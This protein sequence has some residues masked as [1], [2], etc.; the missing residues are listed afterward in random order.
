MATI[1]YPPARAQWGGKKPWMFQAKNG[2]RHCQ[3]ALGT[4][5][6]Q[7][8]GKPHRQIL[9][10]PGALGGVDALSAAARIPL[11]SVTLEVAKP[12]QAWC[13]TK[14]E[15]KGESSGF[16]RKSDAHADLTGWPLRHIKTRNHFDG[17]L[18]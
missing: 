10:P 3:H 1:K 11:A 13:G 12:A 5:R 4:G 9:I 14:A 6:G 18:N 8:P 7:G 15:A 2:C 16:H 17:I